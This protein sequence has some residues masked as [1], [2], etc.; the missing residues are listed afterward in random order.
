MELIIIL[1]GGLVIA[2]GIALLIKPDFI[3]D[4]LKSESNNVQLHYFAI[5]I[6]VII[7][8]LLIYFAEISDYPVIM[9]A[10][11]WFAIIA[12]VALI[13][14]GHNNFQQLVEWAVNFLKPYRYIGGLL[15]IAF[16]AFLMYAFL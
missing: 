6:R 15:A 5:A 4:F 3:F 16:G 13:L 9:E 2:A 1:F 14:I 10:I 7:G 11:G 12:A 8:I